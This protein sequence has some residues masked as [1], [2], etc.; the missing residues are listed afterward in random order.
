MS[1]KP[2]IRAIPVELADILDR[3]P[4]KR[5]ND[6]D[7]ESAQRVRA[8]F[9]AREAADLLRQSHRLNGVQLQAELERLQRLFAVA[10]KSLASGARS[11]QSARRAVPRRRR[12]P[13]RR[14]GIAMK[15]VKT[16]A[17]WVVVSREGARVGSPSYPVKKDAVTFARKVARD[18]MGTLSV[19]DVRGKVV[20]RHSYEPTDGRATAREKV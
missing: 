17:G 16:S 1:D 11:P 7:R 3:P 5:V 4:L 12:R 9:A 19:Y 18:T 6:L 20:E 14:R 15:V 8:E 10:V 2:A 13:Q